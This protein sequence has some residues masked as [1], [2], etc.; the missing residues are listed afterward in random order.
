MAGL[1]MTR[2]QAAAERFVSGLPAAVTAQLQVIY[3]PLLDIQPV[4]V[5]VD[6]DGIRGVIFTS[7]NGVTTGSTQ[8]VR[9]DLP[10]FCVG[11]RT[12]DAAKQA[13]WTV[14]VCAPDA[15]TLVSR[16]LK[17]QPSAPILHL[18]GQHAQGK[19]AARLTAGGIRCEEQ[20][21]YNQRLLQ[22]SPQAISALAAQKEMI[23]PL[24]SPRT[25]RQFADLYPTGA[26]VHLIA[27]SDAVAAPLKALNYKGLQI[28][29][30]P[31][32]KAM[33][34]AVAAVAAQLDLLEGGGAAQ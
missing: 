21:T 17:L 22:L 15:D 27:L 4:P 11:E 30:E 14:K 1:L 23:V 12:A 20:I 9:R 26:V 7:A 6:L 10:V 34:R 24:F 16:V 8:V 5:A 3:A 18:R 19:V 29:S 25:A 31:N 2:P 32:A 13:G 33:A 28:C